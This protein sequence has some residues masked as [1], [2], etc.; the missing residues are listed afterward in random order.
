MENECPTAIQ[1][2]QGEEGYR[3]VQEQDYVSNWRCCSGDQN[4]RVEWKQFPTSEFYVLILQDSSIFCLSPVEN[5]IASIKK[6]DIL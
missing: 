3:L 1:T 4:D 5:V 6:K 2:Q